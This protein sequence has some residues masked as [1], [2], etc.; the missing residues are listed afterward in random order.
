MIPFEPARLGPLT[1]RNRIVKAATFEGMAPAG[2]VSD[3]LVAFHRRVAA[4][5]AAMTTVAYGAVSPEGRTYADQLWMRDDVVAGLRRLTDAVHAEG[6]A[7]ALQLAHAGGFANPSATKQRPIAPSR[8]FNSYALTFARAMRDDDLVRVR[9]AYAR[10]AVLAADAGFDAVEVHLGH[11]YLLSQ[12]LSPAT[13]RRADR[14][15]GD[16]EGR[17]RFPREVL[18]AV[19]D[20]VPA[21]MAVTAKLNMLDG[22]RGGMT[23]EDG[24]EVA[25]M[26]EADG[27]ADALEL[28]GGFTSR[29]PMFLM[30]GEVVFREL[31]ALERNPVRRA[32]LKAVAPRVV[33]PYPFEEA[34]LARYARAV[35]AA[36]RMPLI[37]LGGI[38]RL[39]TIERAHADGFDFVAMARA[40]LRDPS[41]PDDMRAGRAAASRCVPCNRCIVEMQRGGTRCVF[42]EAT[43]PG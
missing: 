15:G 4:G 22:F 29:N 21:T 35:R 40:L 7:A 30:R 24:I 3:R 37:M 42:D 34:F 11:G 23:A 1:L 2:E 31:A 20:A 10:A 33:R 16:V 27:T 32:G 8:A 43:A 25:R 26:L 17:A 39:E 41:L 18:R 38:T 6:A 14:Y 36:V 13:N 12:F 9:D 19:R 5:G 28:T